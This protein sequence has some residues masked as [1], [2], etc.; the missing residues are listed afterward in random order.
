MMDKRLVERIDQARRELRLAEGTASEEELR[1]AALDRQME[2]FRNQ[3]N[4]SLDLSA[5]YLLGIEFARDEE[6]PVARLTADGIGFEL[7]QGD[8]L[9]LVLRGT[10]SKRVLLPIVAGDSQS[11]NRIVCAIADSL[12]AAEQSA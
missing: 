4:A 6:G 11:S 8:G 3:V 7:R 9:N 12:V 5:T 2:E 10:E 1:A